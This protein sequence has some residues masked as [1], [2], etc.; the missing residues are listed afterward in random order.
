MIPIGSTIVLET[1]A[2]GFETEPHLFYREAKQ[3]ANGERKTWKLRIEQIQ[4][5][6]IPATPTT[7]PAMVVE[8]ILEPV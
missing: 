7:G 1:T 3:G 4:P 6:D 8:P 5:E 2:S